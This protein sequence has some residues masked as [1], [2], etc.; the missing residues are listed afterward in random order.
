M[1]GQTMGSSGKGLRRPPAPKQPGGMGGPPQERG[2]SLGGPPQ[3]SMGGPFARW[4][5]QMPR[6]VPSEVPRRLQGGISSGMDEAMNGLGGMR[7]MADML[8]N[9]RGQN[10]GQ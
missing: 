10:N 3:D 5:Q 1:M 9:W 8:R 6:R 4:G 7:G 2:L